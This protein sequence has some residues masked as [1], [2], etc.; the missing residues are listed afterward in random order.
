MNSSGQVNRTR[1]PQKVDAMVHDAPE[2]AIHQ[3]TCDPIPLQLSEISPANESSLNSENFSNSD[4]LIEEI[5][6]DLRIDLGQTSM[7]L[8]EFLRLRNGSVITLDEGV[9][10]PAIILAND[11]PI[12]LGEVLLMNGK[13]SVRVTELLG[14]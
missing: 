9:A 10:E 11:K 1:L 5:E 14:S 3:K 6:V 8:D 12:A 13:F 7:K 2:T 4:S